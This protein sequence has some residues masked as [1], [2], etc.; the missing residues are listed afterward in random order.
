[1]SQWAYVLLS[2]ASD[3]L[4]DSEISILGR[5]F[6]TASFEEC[7]SMLL[8]TTVNEQLRLWEHVE[9]LKA[10]NHVRQKVFTKW[11][12]CGGIIYGQLKAWNEF[13]KWWDIKDCI[14]SSIKIPVGSSDKKRIYALIC[15]YFEKQTILERIKPPAIPDLSE[16]IGHEYIL[17][18]ESSTPNDKLYGVDEES[19]I[20]QV[21]TLSKGLKTPE[22]N[23]SRLACLKVLPE[24]VKIAL[25]ESIINA[26][27]DAT[28]KT[29]WQAWLKET[30]ESG[31]ADSE[32][33]DYDRA[34]LSMLQ[35]STH[36]KKVE[37]GAID[38]F[39][40][41]PYLSVPIETLEIIFGKHNIN[42]KLLITL[43]HFD[44]LDDRE[45]Q[46]FLRE[47]S[48]D[49]LIDALLVSPETVKIKV[50]SNMSKRAAELLGDDMAAK[51]PSLARC[52]RA[53]RE[54]EDVFRK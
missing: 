22:P 53:V 37:V 49:V 50:F 26:F 47:I 8:A 17:T 6:I 3:T 32:A 10:E 27:T 46:T 15:H 43:D 45:I 52:E 51:T 19:I 30:I 41:T 11:I 7:E 1:M 35:S 54:I 33:T 9:N 16:P 38:L 39:A 12:L 14:F 42:K 36:G 21:L 31:P 20:K 24:R 40:L 44:A 48:S 4:T 34:V 13:I 2:K 29:H 5:D 23:V 28:A 18:D 25:F